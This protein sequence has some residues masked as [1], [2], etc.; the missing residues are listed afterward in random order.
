MRDLYAKR[1]KLNLWLKNWQGAVADFTNSLARPDGT[2]DPTVYA[3][4]AE[5]YTAMGN[6]A[7]AINDYSSAVRII[8][9]QIQGAQTMDAR[10]ALS[11]KAMSYFEKSAALNLQ[12]GNMEAARSDLESA[13]TIAIALNDTETATR[14][15]KLIVELNNQ[16]AQ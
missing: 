16:V 2:V 13:Y 15:E 9:E 14:L 8:S 3:D 7:E 4:R 1:G 6:L 11:S 5:A 10:E 12:N